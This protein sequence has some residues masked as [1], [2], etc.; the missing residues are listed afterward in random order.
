MRAFLET[1]LAQAFRQAG[2]Q[3]V[4]SQPQGGQESQPYADIIESAGEYIL[5]AE[6]PGARSGDIRVNARL[7]SVEVVVV[8][9]GMP[10]RIARN[11]GFAKVYPMPGAIDPENIK[12]QYR[13]GILE[14]KAPKESRQKK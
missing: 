8:G 14:V 1:A 12:A 7:R 5:T 4:P 9:R 10:G 3:H 11:V 13:N 6:L 2:V